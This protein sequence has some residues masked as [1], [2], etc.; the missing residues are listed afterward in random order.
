MYIALIRRY[1]FSAFSGPSLPKNH[2]ILAV[3]WKGICFLDESEK[4][5]LEL[6]FP[7]ITGIHTNR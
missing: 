4:R 1:Y 3:N 2:F 5:L 7:E 6:T